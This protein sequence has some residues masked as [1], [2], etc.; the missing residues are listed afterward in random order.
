MNADTILALVGA[1]ATGKTEVGELLAEALGAE[2]VCADSRQ[3]FRELDVGTG[4][5]SK[6]E[7][8][9]RPHHL[10][11]AWSIGDSVSAGEYA[12][13]A[14]AVIRQIR[15]RSRPPLLVGGAGLYLR[16]LRHGLSQEPALDPEERARLR[17]DLA[18]QPVEALHARLASQDPERAGRLRRR[19]R[20]RITRALE[21]V[22][23]SG[24]PLGWW[25]A[26]P[27]Q[28]PLVG[29]WRVVE[30]CTPPAELARRIERR[31]SW[32]FANGL[33]DEARAVREAGLESE[34]RRLRAVGYDEALELLEGRLS[35]EQAEAL[36][37][38]RTRQLAKRQR[39]WFRHQFASERL[40]TEGK[41][42]D[43]LARDALARYE[44][45]GP[46]SG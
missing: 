45:G 35:R 33:L 44:G 4:K 1:T 32:M 36:T 13:R 28:P 40:E 2:I 8:A 16:A 10:F 6:T 21:V 31:T 38:L 5:P 17:A 14:A 37:A 25:H 7:R 42:P 23:L 26:R 3:M 39:T 12:R 9:A 43:S 22:E 19:D 29:E 18:A 46:R 30:L 34:L 15:S 11:D 20:Q 41:N 27:P 24:R